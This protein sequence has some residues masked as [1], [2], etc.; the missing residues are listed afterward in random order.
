MSRRLWSASVMVRVLWSFPATPDLSLSYPNLTRCAGGHVAQVASGALDLSGIRIPNNIHFETFDFQ[1]LLKRR[2]RLMSRLSN[3]LDIALLPRFLKPLCGRKEYDF[4]QVLE[5]TQSLAL[6]P[7]LGI[8]VLRANATTQV[9]FPIAL[10]QPTELD[11]AATYVVV[12]GLGGLGRSIA[13]FLA[14]KGVKHMAI[15]SRSRANGETGAFVRSLAKQGVNIRAVP[16]DICD[17]QALREALQRIQAAM[18]KIK[19]VVQCA[20]VIDVSSFSLQH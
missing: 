20:A 17:E 12:G 3:Q 19:G 6:D 5:A 1:T 2:P 10:S 13:Y 15:L 7:Y 14:E 9:K 4:S 16:A 11:P 18:P 8:H